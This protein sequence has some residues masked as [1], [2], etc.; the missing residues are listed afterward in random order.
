MK[1]ARLD[2]GDRGLNLGSSGMDTT[3]LIGRKFE[4]GDATALQILLVAEVLVGSDE[5]V[6]CTFGALQQFSIL[7]AGPASLLRR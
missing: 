5:Q 1:F 6:K 4:D 3:E 7:D 2:R